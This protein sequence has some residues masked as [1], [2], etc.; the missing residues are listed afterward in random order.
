MPDDQSGP[1]RNSAVEALFDVDV[2][3]YELH[4]SAPPDGLIGDEA[5]IVDKA[6][7]KRRN[8][9]TAGRLCARLAM[10]ELGHRDVPLLAEPSR[11]PN[12]P[13]GLTGSITHTVG[14]AVAVVTLSGDHELGLG[15]D[16]EVVGRIDTSIEEM[17]LGDEERRALDEI[18]SPER[19]V[20]RTAVF[21]AKEAFYKAQW[22]L[23]SSWVGF[24][25]VSARLG[26]SEVVLTPRS[27]LVTLGLLQWP[28]HIRYFES[29]G[30]IVAGCVATNRR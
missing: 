18:R 1:T 25:D 29:A 20:A 14:L 7:A 26:D 8:E 27:G 30:V 17:V 10:A 11:A 9:F 12:W 24:T 21:A 22:P 13:T 2:V 19:P 4:G 15:I 23:T 16:A 6:G 3:A 5:A 28:V